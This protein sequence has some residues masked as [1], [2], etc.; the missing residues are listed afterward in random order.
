VTLCGQDVPASSHICAFFD[1]RHEQD[2]V[3]LPFF[4]EGVENREQ[5][6]SVFD[7]QT[8]PHH[9]AH[10]ADGGLA[11]DDRQLARQ[12][13][14]M[15]AEESFLAAGRFDADRMFGTI[16]LILKSAA[17]GEFPYVRT[18]CEMTWA[19]HHLE[20][21]D[22]LIEYESRLNALVEHHDCTLMCVYDVNLFSGPVLMDVLATHPYV[23]MGQ[24]LTKNPYYVP[25]MQYLE[26]LLKRR[27]AP[28]AR[29]DAL[30][31]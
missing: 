16:E 30:A 8:N 26:R 13:R 21:M 6:V 15:N 20:A 23:L 11:P 7:A 28:A 25:P 2:Q 22:P 24:T 12:L 3:L 19:L 4:L 14:V 31:A 1:S 29:K 18:C 5:V 27:G 9:P 17:Y 10:L